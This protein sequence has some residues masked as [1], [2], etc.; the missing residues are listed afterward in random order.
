MPA[1]APRTKTR[2]T[3]RKAGPKPTQQKLWP[4]ITRYDSDHLDRIALPL[5]GIGTGT[6]S[7]G[8]RGDLR[9][10][11]LMNRPGKNFNPAPSKGAGGYFALLRCKTAGSDPVMRC[12]EG[13]LPP[14]LYEGQ[15]G[16]KIANHSLPRFQNARFDAA[17]PL[18]TVHLSDPQVP[19]TVRVEAF[20]PLIPGDA[21]N[22]GLPIAQ[23]RYVLTNNTSKPVDA[24][25]CATLQNFIGADGGNVTKR[26]WD[27]ELDH[28]SVMNGNRNETRDS[29]DARGLLL[30]SDG[31]DKRDAAWGTMAL[32]LLHAPADAI[33]RRAAWADLSWGDSLLEF[34]D[35]FTADG[36][37]QDQPQG[38]VKDPRASIA[39]SLKVPAKSSVSVTVLLAWHF[40]NRLNW[41][42]RTLAEADAKTQAPT[43]LQ[44]TPVAVTLAATDAPQPAS[45]ESC[46]DNG[47]CGPT[48]HPDY[49]GNYYTQQFAD[50]WDVI[51]QVAHKL[52]MLE[53]Q[54]V[55]FVRAIAD[56]NLPTAVKDA[57]LSNLTA[58]RSQTTFRTPDG[59]PF[60]WEGCFDNKGCCEGSC[61]HVWNYENA[62]GFLFGDLSRRMRKIEFVHCTNDRGLMA[63]RVHLPLATHAQYQGSAAADGQM[64]CVVRAY[65]D[66]KLSGDDDFLR[67]IFPGLRRAIE[68][69]WIEKGW[70]ADRDGVMEG[71]Q[72]N[73]MDVE[74]FGPNPQ[75]TIWYLAALRSAS[76]M[77]RHLGENTFAD[78]CDDLAARGSKWIDKHLFNGDYYEHKI[79]PVKSW[80]DVAPGLKCGMGT[81]NLAD[82]D[83]QIGPGCLIDQL[84]G[85]T[86]AHVAG[87]GHVIDPKK[88]RA[89][90]RAIF[91]H[92]FKSPMW[93]H[94][95]H[96]RTYA[97]QEESALI[98][99]SFPRGNRPKRPFPYYNEVM[100]GFE[101]IAAAG[102]LYEGLTKEGLTCIQAVRDRYDG[103]RRSPFNEAECGHH[104][105]RAMASW[106][107]ILAITGFSFDAS[108]GLMRFAKSDKASS[109]FWS[110]GSAWG[111][112]QQKP[113]A[114]GVSV[115][116]AVSHGSL[117]L[118]SLQITGA[119]TLSWDE[120]L[121]LTAGQSHA[122]TLS[123]STR[124]VT[125]PKRAPRR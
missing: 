117:T 83:L 40:P 20:N 49:V 77:A 52:P 75:M 115:I 27:G 108:A 93:G 104:Y 7:I 45:A 85:Q 60:G 12:L 73:T 47:A 42:P 109:W 81:A 10:F 6:V 88:A 124:K 113:S 15:S 67:E 54:T 55:A 4:V 32:A 21:D 66:W 74:Y 2:A 3:A 70:D 62:V 65:R 25:L 102:M 110:N 68:F 79:V 78:T 92:N 82:P 101:H 91:T 89:A 71:C 119:G 123:K 11:E 99:C 14:S 96:F 17:Y 69:C 9:D 84:V 59:N 24:S 121:T 86:Q 50:A 48:L 63:F 56:S 51:K 35:D 61:T 1:K 87:L 58:L 57:A 28:L 107:A 72:H 53:R 120:P 36:K 103:Q 125:S 114:K 19:L 106:T 8:G 38:N 23:L 30:L 37:L 29:D 94:F 41:Y 13:A 31:V 33:T 44:T 43:Q 5:G 46:C 98:M 118:R 26:N 22:S 116:L 97:L 122:G 95:N 16:A 64:G 18:G 39:V 111:T 112:L 90:M 80:D 105:A 100:T 34:W 76:A